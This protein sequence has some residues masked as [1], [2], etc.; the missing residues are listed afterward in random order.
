MYQLF[1]HIGRQR[2]LVDFDGP[3]FAKL[4]IQLS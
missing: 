3:G 2:G 1:R 4:C